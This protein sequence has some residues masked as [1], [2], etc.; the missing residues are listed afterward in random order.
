MLRAATEANAHIARSKEDIVTIENLEGCYP[1]RMA[2]LEAEESELRQRLAM[3]SNS[4]EHSEEISTMVSR[5]C[6]LCW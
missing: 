1:E 5:C 6:S 2:Q 3:E 4:W